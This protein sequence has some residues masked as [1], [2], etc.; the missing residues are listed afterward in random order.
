MTVQ[1]V[2]NESRGEVEVEPEPEPLCQIVTPNGMLGYGIPE[3]LTAAA[4]EELSRASTPTALILDSGSTDSGPSKLALGSMTCPRSS[5]KQDLDALLRLVVK[6]RVPLLISSAGG[7]GSDR[8]VDEMLEIIREISNEPKNGA[9]NLKIIAMYADVSK[10]IVLQRLSNGKITGCGKSVP[11][12][13]ELDVKKTPT[14]V[15]QMGPE[16]FI[17]AMSAHPD[18]D[19]IIG[20]RAYDPSPYVAFCAFNAMQDRNGQLYDLSI[21]QVGAFTHM[22]KIMECGGLCATP[23]GRG[24]IASIYTNSTFDIKPLDPA[25]KCIPLS[26]AAHSLYEKSRPDLLYGPGGYLDL[27]KASYDQLDDGVSVRVRGST[28]VSSRST[29]TQYTVK[30]E[31][32]KVTGFRTL[33]I[34]SFRDP[35][36]IPQIRSFL[37]AVKEYV[38]QNHEHITESWDLDWH[39][40]GEGYSDREGIFRAPKEVFV[41]AEAIAESQ[42]VA[43]SLASSA[44]IACAH[45]PYPGQKATSGN[46]AMGIG[47]KFEL[48]TGECTE[49][50][51]YH[52]MSLSEGEE[53]AVEYSAG[54]I[55][56]TP[57]FCWKIHRIGNGA[58][59]SNGH[60]D[61]GL[62]MPRT[63]AN[64]ATKPIEK[65][66]TLSTPISKSFSQQPSRN[67]IDIAKI[68]RSKNAGPYELTFDVM[69]DD[70]KV[71]EAVK[72]SAVLSP[73]VISHLYTVAEEDI[74]WCGFFDVAMAFK[75]TIPRTRGGR[76]V[77]SGG[78]MESDVHG[79]QQ[80]VPLMQLELPQSLV[81]ELQLLK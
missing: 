14:I 23:K 11:P 45:G 76:A 1:S 15:A 16:P 59:L 2:Q 72:R 20:G 19:I 75:A 4:L 41:V 30:L 57:L 32:A 49:F 66:E 18:F 33:M 70:S 26:I 39:V 5:Y 78:Y 35:I 13:T 74:I 48:E 47:G 60:A 31:G 52:L 53:G 42:L 43:S 81:E 40:Y 9:M 12:L 36:L 27:T 55:S 69:F 29:G 77:C 25:A 8:H 22:G 51:I 6:Y 50:S 3:A 28:F 56:A 68:I 10:D 65:R 24:A 80:Y 34:G 79:S 7:D 62:T 17:Q 21:P 73:A 37:A 54:N 63:V 44:R 61:G 67:L 46:F 71:Y 64:G 58:T 38:K